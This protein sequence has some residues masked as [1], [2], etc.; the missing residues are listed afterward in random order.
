MP[1]TSPTSRLSYIDWLRGLACLLMFQT[2]CYDS[3][4]RPDLHDSALYKWSQLGG[5]LPA[6]LFIFLAGISMALVTE[7][8]REK[9]IARNTIAKQTIFRG[10]EIF[11]LGT[12][13]RPP[14][15]L[16][17]LTLCS[18][19]QRS[20]LL[21]SSRP[22]RRK[23]LLPL[24]LVRPIARPSLRRLRLLA[25]QS[26]FPPHAL[27][28]S[29]HHPLPR[30]RLVPLGTRAN[31]LQ[32]D[33]PTRHHFATRLLGAHRVRLWTLVHPPQARVF[34]SQ[35]HTRFIFHFSSDVTAVDPAHAL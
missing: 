15:R 31:R 12:L 34:Y 19:P 30:L 24:Q 3:W 9:G 16:S 10:A 18:P 27:R 35:S 33:H 28:H 5:T 11:A 8:L 25:F 20:P 14:A 13:I 29:P 21:L 32:S 4:L 1:P 2:H 22:I 7:R 26:Q 17:L 6:P 23:R